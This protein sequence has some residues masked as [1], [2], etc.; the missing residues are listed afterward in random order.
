VQTNSRPVR[1]RHGVISRST[2][3][4]VAAFRH[5]PPRGRL[6]CTLWQ[7]LPG[8]HTHAILSSRWCPWDPGG[9]TRAGPSRGG[10]PPYLQE[11]KIKESQSIS[12]Q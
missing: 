8:G 2:L 1:R 3:P 4:S 6:R 12:D 9:Y 10:C 7:P 11:S 5:R